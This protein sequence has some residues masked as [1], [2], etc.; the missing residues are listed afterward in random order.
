MITEMQEIKKTYTFVS[1]NHIT[2]YGQ[3][4]LF[5]VHKTS[6]LFS[7]LS[8]SKRIISPCIKLL[9]GDDVYIHQSRIISKKAIVGE[10]FF[11]HQDYAYYH[12]ADDIPNPKLIP[13]VCF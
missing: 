12:F 5:G 4:V 13:V 6:N 3:K 11:W 1:K 7:Q 10:G 8:C 9:G 2:D